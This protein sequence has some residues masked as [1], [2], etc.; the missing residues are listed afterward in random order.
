MFF[1]SFVIDNETQKE[2]KKKKATKDF[3]L[4][5]QSQ[6]RPTVENRDP[7]LIGSEQ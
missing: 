1:F 3:N 6:S 7:D 2:K 4:E 5:P